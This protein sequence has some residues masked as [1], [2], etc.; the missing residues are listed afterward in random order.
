MN[1]EAITTLASS[2]N[3]AR[4]QANAIEEA[5]PQNGVYGDVSTALKN[6][7]FLLVPSRARVDA[8][9]QGL[10]DGATVPEA[11]AHEQAEWD[12]TTAEIM[13]LLTPSWGE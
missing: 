1:T 8:V 7:L 2:L 3:I 11:L 9:Y 13:S 12:A 4:I 10:L 5:A 6:T